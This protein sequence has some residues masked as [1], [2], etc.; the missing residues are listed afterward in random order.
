MER[1]G[2]RGREEDGGWRER[3]EGGGEFQDNDIL[4]FN[5]DNLKQNDFLHDRLLVNFF[6]MFWR[7]LLFTL[8]TVS[9]TR[10]KFPAKKSG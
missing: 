10:L 7:A 4:N 5:F 9:V 3:G 6:T 1:G 2:G 8:P